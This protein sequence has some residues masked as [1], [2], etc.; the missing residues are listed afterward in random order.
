AIGEPA[1]RASNEKLAQPGRM[2][3]ARHAWQSWRSRR[4]ASWRRHGRA[5]S[6]SCRQWDGCPC[7]PHRLR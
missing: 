5:M 1:V 2:R 6:S 4:S 3:P 7:R